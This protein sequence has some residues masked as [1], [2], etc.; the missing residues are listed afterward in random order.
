MT[1]VF[2]EDEDEDEEEISRLFSGHRRPELILNQVSLSVREVDDSKRNKAA[3][4][5]SVV[6]DDTDNDNSV[7]IADPVKASNGGSHSR[8]KK[9]N[10]S[11]SRE[12][13]DMEVQV[14]RESL[15]SRKYPSP[16]EV[17]KKSGGG[18]GR[19]KKSGYYLEVEENGSNPN[20]VRGG[21]GRVSTNSKRN[22]GFH[23]GGGGGRGGGGRGGGSDGES[24]NL[25][26]EAE[27]CSHVR[28]CN[29]QYLKNFSFVFFLYF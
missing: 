21:F 6:S 7:D 5:D 10:N 1:E 3:T 12:F 15:S 17:K 28:H 9:N 8:N 13:K 27:V 18:G 16:V 22:S 23:G 4:V 26:E 25:I 24:Y 14:R 2:G 11:R 19:D 20:F 29:C